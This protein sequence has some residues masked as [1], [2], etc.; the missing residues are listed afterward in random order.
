MRTDKTV[1]FKLANDR[2][3]WFVAALE[4]L[5]YG[6]ATAFTTAAVAEKLTRE[7]MPPP[8]D[9]TPRPPGGPRPA[10]SPADKRLRKQQADH[11]E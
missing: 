3:S 6:S 11:D 10:R 7:G 4:Q 8:F 5:G 1:S 2:Y 9:M